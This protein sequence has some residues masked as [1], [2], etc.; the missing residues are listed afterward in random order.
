MSD[1]NESDEAVGRGRGLVFVTVLLAALPMLYLLSIGPVFLISE[2]THY[3]PS[4]LQNFYSP[5]VWLHGHT[6]LKQPIEIYL[7]LWGIK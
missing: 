7:G 1:K 6:F 3:F 2:K 4:F 5:I